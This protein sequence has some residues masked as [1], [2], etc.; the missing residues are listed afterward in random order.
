[1]NAYVERVLNDL[2]KKDA[3]QPEF[4]QSVEEVL[5]STSIVFDFHPLY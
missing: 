4:L 2:K 1:M 5:T 3:Y